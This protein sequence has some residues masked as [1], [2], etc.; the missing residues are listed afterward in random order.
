MEVKNHQA[1]FK[2]LLQHLLNNR[3]I[4]EELTLR[5]HSILMNG[6]R[7]DAGQ[8]RN[9]AV[10]IAGSNVPTAN[11]MKVPALMRELM[12]DIQKA[13]KDIIGFSTRVHSRFEQ[14]HPFSDG[15]GR[16]GR[17]LLA[18]MLLKNDLPMSIIP[19]EQRRFYIL[20][21]NQ[22]QMKNDYSRLENFIC[23]GILAG[24]DIFNPNAV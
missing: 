16:V 14:I 8:Y 6:I 4:S 5:I 15:N 11:Y 13:E 7:D 24:Y 3:K 12:D 18:A 20:Y 22:A 9:H 10:R 21:L 1:A 19:Q 23:D 17:L 2:H